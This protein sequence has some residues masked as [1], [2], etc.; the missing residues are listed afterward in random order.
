MLRNATIKPKL[1]NEDVNGGHYTSVNRGNELQ[2]STDLEFE[3][4]MGHTKRNTGEPS[5][6]S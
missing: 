2:W 4:F 3:I 6:C 5:N 1:I